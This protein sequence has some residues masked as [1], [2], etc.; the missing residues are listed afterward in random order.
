MPTEA[1]EEY[2]S[3][4]ELLD[5]EEWPFADTIG[6]MEHVR[7]LWAYSDHGYWDAHRREDGTMVYRVSTAGWSGNEDLIAA[8][9]KNQIW[10]L[11]CWF[12]STRG[13]HYEFHCP[14]LMKPSNAAP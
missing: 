7:R 14:N 11:T 9:K 3:D 13:G 1:A 6:L 8:L 2:P 12:S 10:W 4:E 5:I